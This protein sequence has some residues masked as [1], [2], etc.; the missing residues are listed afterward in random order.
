MTA[1][2]QS[3][4]AARPARWP[5]ILVQTFLVLIAVLLALGADEWR[6]D[7]GLEQLAVEARTALLS[8][9]ARN[10]DELARGEAELHAVLGNVQAALA[11]PND[12][13]VSAA[14]SVQL[15]LALLSSAAWRTAQSS[16]ALRRLD[17]DWVIQ[18]SQ[19]YELQDMYL[20]AQ[21][22]AVDDVVTV[23][24]SELSTQ[25]VAR[26]LIGRLRMLATLHAGLK[27]AYADV[28]S[29]EQT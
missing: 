9:V 10:R 16:D 15:D 23:S 8:E 29:A 28:L 1:A 26:K 7:R 6:E 5:E 4:G 18:V 12:S 20:R 21:W 17:Y 2:A 19:V 3:D 11:A 13:G 14:L 24:A 27:T 22:S 25:A